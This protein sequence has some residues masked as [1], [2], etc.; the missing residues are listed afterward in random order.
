LKKRGRRGAGNTATS[1]LLIRV[2]RPIR[3]IRGKFFSFPSANGTVTK[4]WTLGKTLISSSAPPRSPREIFLFIRVIRLIRV[5]RGKS[6]LFRSLE[7]AP[8]ALELAPKANENVSQIG[9]R[10]KTAMR[11]APDA[12]PHANSS[13]RVPPWLI[14]KVKKGFL[15][16]YFTLQ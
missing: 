3:V 2:I 9:V 11:L 12:F 6:L 4:A 7:L 8:K 1:K 5:I 10:H 14:L 16:G 15:L 13:L